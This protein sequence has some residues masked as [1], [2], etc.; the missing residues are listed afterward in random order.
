[1]CCI[2]YQKIDKYISELF[3]RIKVGQMKGGET[4]EM[5]GDIR[6]LIERSCL[7]PWLLK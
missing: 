2:V 6:G 4:L 7:S 1:M 3:F 5:E